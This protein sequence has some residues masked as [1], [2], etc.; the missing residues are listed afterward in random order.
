MENKGLFKAIL[1][2]NI[3]IHILVGAAL[4][5]FS[6]DSFERSHLFIGLVILITGLPNLLIYLVGGGHKEFF[7]HPYIIFSFVAVIIG[8]IFILCDELSVVHMCLVWGILDIVRSAY[9]IFD[10]IREL[11]HD[12]LEI[13]E[14]IAGTADLILGVLLTIEKEEG[15]RMHLIIMGAAL[16][17]IGLRFIVELIIKSKEKKIAE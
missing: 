8:L 4:I 17:L 2:T 12:K 15:I 16:I 11:K 5:V 1:V 14:I 6:H 3:I 13:I 10:A 7:K 9:E